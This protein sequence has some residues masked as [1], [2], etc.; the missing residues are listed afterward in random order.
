MIRAGALALYLLIFAAC[1]STS[2]EERARA[3]RV[4]IVNDKEVGRECQ[5]I[6][7]VTDDNME[8]LQKKASQGWRPLRHSQRRRPEDPRTAVRGSLGERMGIP[9]A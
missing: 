6:G 2:Q 9:G 8:D 4:R 5:P 7:S 3:A 1:A